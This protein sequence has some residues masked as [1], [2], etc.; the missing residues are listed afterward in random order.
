MNQLIK[1]YIILLLVATVI[2]RLVAIILLG[3]YPNLLTT[4]LP[5]GSTST[6]GD[7][8]LERFFEYLINIIFV[9]LLLKEM[10][11]LKF[12]SLPILVVTFLSS[13]I[14]IIFFLFAAAGKTLETKK[15]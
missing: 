14:G 1:K 11:R 8:Y 6:L 4:E 7:A 13:Y 9:I 10:R 12:I 3:I 5:D 2:T 15:I